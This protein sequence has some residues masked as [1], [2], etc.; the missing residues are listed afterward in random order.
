MEIKQKIIVHI[1]IGQINEGMMLTLFLL[2]DV[3]LELSS[4]KALNPYQYDVLWSQLYAYL[5]RVFATLVNPT[6]C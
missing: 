6:R 2:N 3:T 5:P 4:W 1:N